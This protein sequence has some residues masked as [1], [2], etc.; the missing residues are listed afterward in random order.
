VKPPLRLLTASAADDAVLDTALS[1]ALLARAPEEAVPAFR[2]SRP[3]RTVSF[4]RLDRLLPGFPAATAAARRAGFAPVLRVGGGRAAALHEDAILYGLAAPATGST[5]ERFVAMADLV[6]AALRRLGIEAEVGE[7]AGEYCP[8]AWSL[9]A[10]GVKLAGIAQRVTRGG[11][12]TEGFLVV[13]GGD[14]IR[15][16][17]EDV[18]AA[19]GL[20][21]DP[22]T[23]GALEDVAPGVTHAA[24]VAALHDELAARHTL[25]PVPASPA[26]LALAHAGRA[27]HTPQ[28][29]A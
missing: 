26:L 4:G 13:R 9:H 6:R 20:T 5:T 23:A 3:P 10:G 12:W 8:G 16:V 21:W 7:L 2:L 28:P 17:L 15:A 27:R 11:A 14:R 29:P 24:A 25:T 22:G 1:S 19:L 18:Y